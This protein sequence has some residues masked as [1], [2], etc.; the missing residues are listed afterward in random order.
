MDI[1]SQL[2]VNVQLDEETH[3]LANTYKIPNTQIISL[4]C[5]NSTK[6][7]IWTDYHWKE[8]IKHN[9]YSTEYLVLDVKKWIAFVIDQETY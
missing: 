7:I 6:K 2:N 4:V 8:W 5:L 1:D 9:I 3:C